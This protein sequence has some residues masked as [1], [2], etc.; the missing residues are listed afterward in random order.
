M[1]NLFTYAY[2]GLVTN[3]F[4]VFHILRIKPVARFWAYCMGRAQSRLY[5][6]GA[7]RTNTDIGFRIMLGT[8]ALWRVSPR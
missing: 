1:K 6:A 5:Y 8:L 7:L 3:L 4:C 2:I